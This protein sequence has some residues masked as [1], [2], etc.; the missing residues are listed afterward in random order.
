MFNVLGHFFKL[1]IKYLASLLVKPNFSHKISNKYTNI[2]N[3]HN[4]IFNNNKIGLH[5]LINYMTNVSN[6]KKNFSTTKW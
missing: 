3:F 4:N 1:H 2:S 5:N 6:M